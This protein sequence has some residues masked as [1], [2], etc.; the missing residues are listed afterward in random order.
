M[1][2]CVYVFVFACV[3]ASVCVLAGIPVCTDVDTD[4][5]SG[6][7]HCLGVMVL[8]ISSRHCLAKNRNKIVFLS[9]KRSLFLLFCQTLGK[10]PAEIRQGVARDIKCER[11]ELV[12]GQFLVSIL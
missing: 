7:K 4:D 12:P 9:E 10:A 1:H 3:C 2:A 6:C 8:A 5:I 11:L